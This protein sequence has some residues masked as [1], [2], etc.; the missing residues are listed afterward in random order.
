VHQLTPVAEITPR[1]R[2]WNYRWAQ[3]VWWV[4]SLVVIV[5]LASYVSWFYEGRAFPKG[6]ETLV[7]STVL[8]FAAGSYVTQQLARHDLEHSVYISAFF[9]MAGLFLLLFAT[10]FFLRAYYSR[11]F[12]LTAFA[13]SIAATWVA[14]HLGARSRQLVFGVLGD[15]DLDRYSNRTF[16]FKTIVDPSDPLDGVDGLVVDYD[17]LDTKWQSCVAKSTVI[18]LPVYDVPH[19]IEMATGRVSISHLSPGQA[20]DFHLHP[21]YAAIKRLIDLVVAALLLAPLLV[22]TLFVGC[23]IKLESAGP[24]FFRQKRVGQQ[25]K[26]FVIFKFR[27]MHASA[28]QN[29]HSFAKADDPRVTRVGKLLRRT[30]LDELP[31]LFNV[32]CGDMSLS[33]PRPEQVGFV[34]QFEQSIPFYTYRHLVKPGITGWAQVSHGY[35]ASEAATRDK[36]EYDLYYAKYCSVWL[37]LLIAFRTLRTILTGF[38]SR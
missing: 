25:G 21:V 36:L 2:F 9:V 10:L 27:S 28:E 29:G 12:L 20:R 37:D 22:V 19:F 14:L 11:S 23:G 13:V 38:G 16:Q 18:G 5:G 6:G 31:Q 3:A 35:T 32:L 1:V 30:R 17:Q 34:R 33:G 26:E 8:T 4:T 24:V 15:H 7:V